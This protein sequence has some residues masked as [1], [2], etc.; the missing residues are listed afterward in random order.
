MRPFVPQ[1]IHWLIQ[2]RTLSC[3]VWPFLCQPNPLAFKKQLI[4]SLFTCPSGSPLLIVLNK[5]KVVDDFTLRQIPGYLAIV[6]K[7]LRKKKQYIRTIVHKR[8]C[9]NRTTHKINTTF[10]T[11][12][13]VLPAAPQPVSLTMQP[14]GNFLKLFFKK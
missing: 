1:S 2:M 12:Q 3:A 7:D 4:L 5:L 11:S 10:C 8:Y 6:W 13:L 9:H 14:W